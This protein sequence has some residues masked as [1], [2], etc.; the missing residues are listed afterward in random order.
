MLEAEH[1]VPAVKRILRTQAG[2]VVFVSALM[3]ALFGWLEARSA[4]LGGL[5]GFLPNAYFG[6]RI[7][8]SKGEGAQKI[9]RTFYAGE[10]VKIIIT[11]V[12]F[13]LILQLPDIL[14]MPLFAGFVPVIMVFWFALLMRST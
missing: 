3:L 1:V 10:S 5:A 6:Y 13:F 14:F 2:V 11:A 4:F 9:V 12:L 8:R 7:A